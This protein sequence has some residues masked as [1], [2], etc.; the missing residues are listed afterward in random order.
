MSRIW[1]HVKNVSKKHS[2]AEDV[3]ASSLPKQS[4]MGLPTK[5]LSIMGVFQDVLIDSGCTCCIIYKKCAKKITKKEVSV[6]TVNGQ[7]QQCEGVSQTRIATPN[8]NTVCVEA[9]VVDFKPLG[10]CFLMGMNG[11]VALGGV[12][13]SVTRDIYF[14]GKNEECLL[15]L[16]SDMPKDVSDMNIIAQDFTA[17]FE[18]ENRDWIIA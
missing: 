18:K 13:I 14:M 1:T 3:C 9:L 7:Q 4:V 6:V 10:F 8:G 16:R 11:I 15:G 2:E 12:S 17:S 5:R